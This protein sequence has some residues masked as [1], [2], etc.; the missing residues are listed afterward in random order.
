MRCGQP[1]EG[2]RGAL[3]RDSR[4]QQR[5]Q[6]TAAGGAIAGAQIAHLGILVLQPLKALR[7]LAVYGDKL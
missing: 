5:T 6:F 1:T 3:G 2:G 7:D 4:L